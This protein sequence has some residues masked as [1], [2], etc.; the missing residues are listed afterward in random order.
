MPL[1]PSEVT[2]RS[3]NQSKRG[4]RQTPDAPEE[5]MRVFNGGKDSHWGKAKGTNFTDS[6]GNGLAVLHICAHWLWSHLPG[7]LCL[8]PLSLQ[9][10]QLA[11]SDDIEAIS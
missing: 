11:W 6:A 4:G 5:M 10:Q 3:E 8:S 7:A 2:T 1:T 9:W